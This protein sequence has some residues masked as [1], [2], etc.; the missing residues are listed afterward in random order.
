MKWSA[1]NLNICT[2]DRKNLRFM[3]LYLI[4]LIHS[5]YCIIYFGCICHESKAATPA[6]VSPIV[7]PRSNR[8]HHNPHTMQLVRDASQVTTQ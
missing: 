3:D 8:P 2:G 7:Y 4:T 5:A 6:N 1:N